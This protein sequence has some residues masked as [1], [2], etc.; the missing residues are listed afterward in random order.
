MENNAALG[1]A[2]NG[3]VRSIQWRAKLELWPAY[4]TGLV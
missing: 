4:I 2:S 1:G 3:I